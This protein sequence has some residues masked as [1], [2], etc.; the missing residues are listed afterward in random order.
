MKPQPHLTKEQ[1][2]ELGSMIDQKSWSR[3]SFLT[4]FFLFASLISSCAGPT[5]PWGNYG[6]T[7]PPQGLNP[8]ELSGNVDSR[9]NAPTAPIVVKTMDSLAQEEESNRDILRAPSS[10]SHHIEDEVSMNFFPKRQN[11]H[12]TTEFSVSI[13]DMKVIPDNA[14]LNLFYNGTNVTSAWLKRAKISYN[15]DHRVM[16]VNFQGIKL[17]AQKNHNITVSYQRNKQSQPVTKKYMAPTCSLAALEPLGDLVP[18][19]SK[20]HQYRHL[21][22]GISAQESVN[23]SLVAGLI[24]QE[25][26]FNPMAV[27]HAKAIGLTQVTNGASQHVLETFN[28]YPTYPELH[29]FPV[30]LIKTMILTGQVNSKNEWRLNPRT[31]IRGGITY[32]KFVEDYWLADHAHQLIL[33]SYPNEFDVENIL[34]DIILAS[35]NSGPYRVKKALRNR[36]Q[37]WLNSPHLQEAKKYVRKVKSYCYHFSANNNVRPRFAQE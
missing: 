26:A 25:S 34:D 4:G 33:Q 2:L 11:F 18:F 35:Y 30:P 3:P 22:E 13:R 15:D 7:L 21:I 17:L 29:T 36:G 6:M 24:A 19:E 9:S 1:V 12:Q 20:Q 37:D 31:S 10:L 8:L 14:E 16:K 23:P 32:L 28:D 5:N 27:S